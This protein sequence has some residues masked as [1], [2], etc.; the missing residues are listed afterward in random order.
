MN[1]ILIARCMLLPAFFLVIMVGC[2]TT[3][4]ESTERVNVMSA[5]ENVGY[6]RPGYYSWGY[7]QPG[8]FYSPTHYPARAAM[9]LSVSAP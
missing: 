2:S 1:D 3:H 4:I 8:V 5:K 6:Y 7:Y 9:P